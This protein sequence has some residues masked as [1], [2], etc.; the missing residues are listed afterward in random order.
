L[1]NISSL[2][3]LLDSEFSRIVVVAVFVEQVSLIFEF[4]VL[5]REGGAGVLGE[6]RLLFD[7][8]D[9]SEFNTTFTFVVLEND[10]YRY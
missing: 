4:K 9:F 3:I 7:W 2:P 10:L 5:G 6:N 1:E 8:L